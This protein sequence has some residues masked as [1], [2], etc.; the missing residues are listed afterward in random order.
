MKDY[1]RSDFWLRYALVSIAKAFRLGRNTVRAG[2]FPIAFHLVTVSV[3][4]CMLVLSVAPRRPRRY[5]VTG[6]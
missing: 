5:Y 3:P 6:E 2:F 1:P 4:V